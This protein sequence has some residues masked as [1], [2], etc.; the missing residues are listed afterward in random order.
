MGLYDKKIILPNESLKFNY[1]DK[2]IDD[3]F[4]VDTL[5][6]SR[7]TKNADKNLYNYL[8][9]T[10]AFFEELFTKYPFNLDDYFVDIGCGKGRSLMMASLFGCK[11]LCGVEINT[12]VYETLINNFF[13]WK[14]HNF[15]ENVS[16]DLINKSFFD[17]EIREEWNK[18]FMFKPF[19]IDVFK[20]V[21]LSI[22]E[23]KRYCDKMV[24][25]YLYHPDYELV[26]WIEKENLFYLVEKDIQAVENSNGLVKR[27]VRS[28]IYSNYNN[29]KSE[30]TYWRY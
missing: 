8:P 25:I 24:Y 1:I 11:H 26:E 12:K 3:F 10:Y 15:M 17:V 7:D 5:G 2:L 6:N 9:T 22:Y 13:S 16:V 28:S 18:F 14:R 21:M 23:T 4:E 29:L 20:K 27:K 19:N 30:K